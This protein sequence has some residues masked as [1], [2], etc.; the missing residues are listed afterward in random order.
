MII[1]SNEEEKN[2]S[3]MC[4]IE[5]SM[6]NKSTLKDVLRGSRSLEVSRAPFSDYDFIRLFIACVRKNGEVFFDRKQLAY[7]LYPYY[8]GDYKILF[9]D[10]AIKEQIEGNF[11][12]IQE[13]LQ[14]ASLGGLITAH[15]CGAND[16]RRLILITEE[17]SN[18]I[19]E[20]YPECICKKMNDLVKMY[21][22]DREMRKMISDDFREEDIKETEKEVTLKR[23]LNLY[24]EQRLEHLKK[25]IAKDFE[26]D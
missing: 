21:L 22:K 5:P 13:P 20:K 17:E 12:E 26:E 14:K 18:S 19:T 15:D 11:L 8:L 2:Q 7:D 1:N 6:K 10:I 16:T 9:Q 3:T 4:F 25:T 24:D 23:T